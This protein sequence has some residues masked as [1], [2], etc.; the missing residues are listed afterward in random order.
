[1]LFNR[2]DHLI[3]QLRR[4]SEPRFKVRLNALKLFAIGVHMAEGDAFGPILVIMH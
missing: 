2:L 4:F 3:A 1:M